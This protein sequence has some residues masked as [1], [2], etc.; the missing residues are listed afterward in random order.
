MQSWIRSELDTSF[1]QM[2]PNPNLIY[3]NLSLNLSQNIFE[4]QSQAQ[5][6]AQNIWTQA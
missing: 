5:T 3:M 4:H 1:A 2:N 6:Q